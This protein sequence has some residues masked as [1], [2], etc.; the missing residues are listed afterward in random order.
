MF[1]ALKLPFLPTFNDIQFKV[2]TR[3][4]AKNELTFIGLGAIDLNALNLGIKNP[5][6]QQKYILSQ[7]PVNQQW[8]YT[9]GAVYKHYSD[10]SYQTVAVSQ[11]NLN[12]STVKY[13]ENDE[14][15]PNNKILDYASQELENR[16]RFKDNIRMNGYKL[17][18]GADLDFAHYINTTFQKRFYSGNVLNVNYDTAFNL[19][20]Y[21]MFG[22]IS[23]AILKER[24]TLSAGFRVDANTYSSGMDNLLNQ[25]SPRFSASYQLTEKWSLNMNTGRYFQLPAYT[26]LGYKQ[27]GQFVNKTND[28]KYISVD[29]YIL[30]VEYQPA[31]AMQFSVEG[32]LKNYQHYPFSVKDGISLA[33][34]G[35]DY[36]VIGDEEVTS[37][38]QGIAYG[39]EFQARISSPKYNLNLSYTLVLSEFQD[40]NQNYIVSN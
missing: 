31:T 28:L 3:F 19:L 20:K 4:D 12:N 23:L 37:T 24:L 16:I 2:K 33:N 1:T 10:K 14:S 38:S 27:N 40:G 29:H 34:K 30:G 26:T 39:A 5:D 22:Q 25:F 15:S 17:N 7:I 35:A 9:F 36:G 13:L 8:S 18:V 11:S 32:F 6:D 21:G